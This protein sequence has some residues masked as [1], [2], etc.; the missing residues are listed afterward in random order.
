MIRAVALDFDGVLAES[1]EVKTAAFAAMYRGEGA[2]VEQA[3]VD[4]HRAHTGM[5]RMGKFRYFEEMLLG[6]RLTKDGMEALC[7]RF[8]NLVEEA[9]RKA[10][11][12]AGA[13]TA[14]AELQRQGR[15]LFVISATPA[16][17]I[18]AVV[19]SRGWSKV[20][21][22]VYGSPTP[23]AEHLA[24]ILER[25]GWRSWEAV[26][27]GDA[28]ADW[29][30]ARSCGVHFVGRCRPGDEATWAGISGE[31]MPDLQPLP[32]RVRALDGAAAREERP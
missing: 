21:D 4:Y 12:V 5:S 24:G 31:R 13:E 16:E 7:L 23:K 14:L 20:F 28:R 3:V 6:R 11:A 32:A 2:E 22:G 27:V 29:E 18:V 9:V 25:G 15:R 26:F 19:Q 8:R 30:A 1:V 10:P 17:E